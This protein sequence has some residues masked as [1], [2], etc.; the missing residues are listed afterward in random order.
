[1]TNNYEDSHLQDDVKNDQSLD[2][3]QI[4]VVDDSEDSLLL[5]N[6]RRKW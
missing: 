5:T 1:M 6:A 2:G 3:L 4:L